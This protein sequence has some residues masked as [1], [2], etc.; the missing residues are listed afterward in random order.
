VNLENL[1][2]FAMDE[3]TWTATL[4]PGNRLGR[5]TELMYQAGGRHVPHG[6]SFDIGLGGH[7]TVG[8]A[9]VASRMLGL[10][11][12]FVEEVE[13]VLANSSI[14]RASESV[15]ADLFFAVRG[16]ASSVGI[17]TEFTM[18]TAPAP[19]STISY[20]FVW[21]AAD[22]AS[23]AQVFKSWQKWI[24]G[25]PLPRVMSSTL[26]VTPGAMIMSGAYFGSQTDFEA[27]N[28]SSHFPEPQSSTAQVWTNFLDVSTAWSKEIDGSGIASPTYF[29]SK[30]LV[31]R[32]QTQVP[33]DVADCVFEYLATVTNGT[34]LW[35]VNF[36]VGGGAVADVAPPETAMVHRDALFI[37]LSYARTSGKVTDT[38]V[39]FLDGLNRL[40]TSGHPDAYY[41]EYGGYVD[42]KEN[43]DK[44]RYDYFGQNLRRLE[45]V[46]MAVDPDDVF[47]NQQSVRPLP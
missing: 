6:L 25:V 26:T 20:S 45:Q 39:R 37:M 31:F 2:D 4:G 38:T 34:Q 9:G 15:N 23:R 27:L 43:N 28:I 17:V 22:V 12:D 44:A 40:I 41:G 1:Q 19:P 36:E 42:P 24:A 5:V 3:S 14:V 33:D 8:G 10:T 35:A 30:S 47:H 13:V 11:C 18:R 32:Q 46:K 21:T 7:A 29:Y 16:A